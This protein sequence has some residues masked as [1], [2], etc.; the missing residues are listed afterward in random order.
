MNVRSVKGETEITLSR[1]EA[2]RFTEVKTFCTLIEGS[3]SSTKDEEGAAKAAIFY[4]DKLLKR[5]AA[6]HLDDEGNLI[7]SP[8]RQRTNES[9]PELLAPL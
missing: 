6:K 9:E 5:H 4:L 2:S 7:E 1:S 3:G 8:A